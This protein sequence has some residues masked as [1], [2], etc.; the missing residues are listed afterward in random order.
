ML[1]IR[2]GQAMIAVFNRD[3]VMQIPGEQPNAYQKEQRG[4]G[5]D[6]HDGSFVSKFS[7]A[8]TRSSGVQVFFW[9]KRSSHSSTCFHVSSLLMIGSITYYSL[10]FCIPKRRYT[11][12][13]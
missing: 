1:A 9:P 10:L 8:L 2:N 12:A 6:F 13:P 11:Q 7:A 4:K 5:I 3:R